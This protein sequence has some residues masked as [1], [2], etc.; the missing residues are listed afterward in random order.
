M[1]LKR[2]EAKRLLLPHLETG[3]AGDADVLTGLGGDLR[4][5]VL[6]RLPLV[7]LLVEVLLVQ[8]RDLRCPL[9]ELA[10]HDLLDHVLGLA[11]GS[12]LFL[13][14]RALAGDVLLGDVLEGD[15]LGVH[16]RDVDRDLAGELL[17]VLV[18][19]NEVGFTKY[20]DE[21]A[22][23]RIGVDVGGDH[24]LLRAACAALGARRRA[25]L[26]EDLDRRLLITLGLLERVLY[27]HH[28]G[29]GA[30]PQLLDLGCADRHQE[31]PPLCVRAGSGS[32]CCSV[33]WVSP[34]PC[35]CPA[36]AASG[37]ASVCLAAACALASASALAFASASA[38]AFASASCRAFSSA[39]RR[40][41]SSSSRRLRSSSSARR[42]ASSSRH[43]AAA[44]SIAEPSAPMTRSHERIA[45]SLPGTT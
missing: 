18:S 23:P 24:A 31:S 15:V 25:L 26:P 8:E 45:S 7:E 6:D 11:V 1:R 36:R 21:G 19:S 43:F 30:L 28:R 37:G 39:S 42:R 33:G 13:E 12:G 20:F 35:S 22:L 32:G 34:P 2:A 14:D 38:F 10:V 27:I 41:R 40:F 9:L 3:E 4:S 5:E 29:A 16:R 17:E 44:P